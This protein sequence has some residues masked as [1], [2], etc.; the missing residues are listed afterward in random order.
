MSLLESLKGATIDPNERNHRRVWKSR[1][2][3]RIIEIRSQGTIFQIY[4][5]LYV[6]PK[7]DFNSV[8]KGQLYFLFADALTH[9]ELLVPILGGRPMT[10]Q[11]SYSIIKHKIRS[12]FR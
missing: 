12:L 11:A 6:W 5:L 7:Q 3:L 1:Y 10:L 4:A 2:F 9:R 8:S